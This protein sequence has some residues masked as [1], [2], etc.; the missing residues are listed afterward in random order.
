[1]V[2]HFGAASYDTQTVEGYWYHEGTL[3]EDDSVRLIVDVIDL[4]K[5]RRWMKQF[6]ER[7]RTRLKQLELWMVS[8]RIEVE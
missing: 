7:W 5:N 2:E 4:T 6:K 8:Y 3:Y 1:M